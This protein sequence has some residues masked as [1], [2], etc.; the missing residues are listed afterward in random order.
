V[1]TCVLH[2]VLCCIM[3]VMVPASLFAAD[4]GA[5][6]LYGSGATWLN[7][8]SLPKSSAI[9]TGDLVQTT[10]GAFAKINSSGS[11]LIVLSDSLVQLEANAIAL[12]HGGVAVST[13]KAMATRAGDVTVTPAAG[14]W[15]RFDVTNLD[16][17]VQIVARKGDLTID[18]GQGTTTLAQG[19]Q[20][21][22][23]ETEPQKKKKKKKRA[24]GAIPGGSGGIL[25]SPT[26]IWIGGATVAGIG[27][28]VLLQ[29]G[30]PVSATVP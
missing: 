12:E 22:R 14:V 30:N 5:A 2:K 24:A 19:Q 18:D 20:T 26:A 6:M 27:T 3:A 28:W 11:S 16:G 25:D 23:D 8:K 1:R 21:T 29:G 13:S 7:G 10:T 4:S 15:T 9:F 17:K